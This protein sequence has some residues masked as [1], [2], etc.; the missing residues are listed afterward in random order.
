MKKRVEPVESN[1]DLASQFIDVALPL[2][3]LVSDD[4]Q[5]KVCSFLNYPS[6]LSSLRYSQALT[7]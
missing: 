2:N 1:D 6:A 3:F 5:L 7:K 4:G